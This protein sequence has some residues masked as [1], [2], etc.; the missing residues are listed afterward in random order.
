MIALLKKGL[1]VLAPE[2]EFENPTCRYIKR[3]MLKEAVETEN[4][5]GFKTNELCMF[6]GTIQEDEQILKFVQEELNLKA[7]QIDAE[8]T[9]S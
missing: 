3:K 9:R 4:S 1:R 6:A 5:C 8:I 2:L 7:V